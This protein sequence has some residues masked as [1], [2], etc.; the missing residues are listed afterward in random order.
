MYF[1][2][3]CDISG[4]NMTINSNSVNSVPP[5]LSTAS[6]IVI[7]PV[8]SIPQN[9]SPDIP[10][11]RSAGG[12]GNSTATSTCT[13]GG[14]V[15]TSSGISS[16]IITEP[17]A[18]PSGLGP[19]QS[20]PLVIKTKFTFHCLDQSTYSCNFIVLFCYCIAVIKEGNRLGSFR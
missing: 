8:N 11:S 9:L 4:I 10:S 17:V 14:L 1:F 5:S 3:I 19:V 13:S 18:G 7:P 2:H 15:S 6:T 20:V 16:P 12:L